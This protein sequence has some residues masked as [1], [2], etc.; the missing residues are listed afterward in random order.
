MIDE[1]KSE[2]AM[3]RPG[4]PCEVAPCY[5]LLASEDGSYISGQTLHPNGGT[6]VSG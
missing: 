6:V 3:K 5:V 2:A 4:Q 1:W